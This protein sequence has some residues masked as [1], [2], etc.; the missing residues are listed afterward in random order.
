MGLVYD[1]HKRQIRA[2][3]EKA[4]QLQ[5]VGGHANLHGVLT[6][7]APDT[8]TT[9]LFNQ[10][11]LQ[12]SNIAA[13]A[14]Y[15]EQIDLLSTPKGV[16]LKKRHLS[17]L[18]NPF[19]SQVTPIFGGFQLS[20]SNYIC[21][22]WAVAGASTAIKLVLDIGGNTGKKAETRSQDI[23]DQYKMVKNWLWI[24]KNINLIRYDQANGSLIVDDN[25][26]KAFNLAFKTMQ[27]VY[28]Y[29]G[30]IGRLLRYNQEDITLRVMSAVLQKVITE[31]IEEIA[32]DD[33]F[34]FPGEGRLDAIAGVLS[35]KITQNISLYI[36]NKLLFVTNIPSIEALHSCIIPAFY[37]AGAGQD[38]LDLHV[39]GQ[40]QLLQN[41]MD[42]NTLV[43]T[44][45]NFYVKS[46]CAT[47]LKKASYPIFLK[48]AQ[49]IV[50]I[51]LDYLKV[52]PILN[53]AGSWISENVAMLPDY[54]SW[55]LVGASV[56][57][58]LLHQGYTEEVSK[59]DHNKSLIN[60][61]F[62]DTLNKLYNA[63]F[64]TYSRDGEVGYRV[65][66][67]QKG[68][69]LK[70][71]MAAIGRAFESRE[72]IKS[73]FFISFLEER[74]P[75]INRGHVVAALKNV[76]FD[77]FESYE[78]INAQGAISWRIKEN[79][80]LCAAYRDFKDG[81][82]KNWAIE[83]VSLHP[84]V[85]IRSVFVD[86]LPAADKSLIARKAF[87][88]MSNFVLEYY[89]RGDL[90]N[91]GPVKI[92]GLAELIARLAK[93]AETT[94]R[95]KLSNVAESFSKKIGTGTFVTSYFDPHNTLYPAC[96]AIITSEQNTRWQQQLNMERGSLDVPVIEQ[97]E[98]GLKRLGKWIAGKFARRVQEEV[99]RVAND[100]DEEQGIV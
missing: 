92:K 11:L 59:R 43:P 55:P 24:A 48:S 97:G 15:S 25:I 44:V 63:G 76:P 89:T 65:G 90:P 33:P 66:G 3:E 86:H 23:A 8:E 91:I 67:G 58:A 28:E 60:T 18:G 19:I 37:E 46:N 93:D 87:T 17:T 40:S 94:P 14:H 9:R 31:K 79:V 69:V 12:F 77:K 5:G 99:E 96:K 83:Y 35:D 81:Q 71:L 62:S 36:K 82:N 1:A 75:G 64:I 42:S 41:L 13:N 16:N 27:R 70:A 6:A 30:S 50:S 88:V 47:L 39:V 95:S 45:N 10:L 74:C 4:I 57:L 52:W 98:G 68:V 53:V 72:D 54:I 2:L 38:A 7:V 84:G 29:T 34:R 32:N 21:N 85:T 49:E 26:Y 56:G 61:Q 20:F 22:I 80:D 78:H 73:S 51:A 100:M